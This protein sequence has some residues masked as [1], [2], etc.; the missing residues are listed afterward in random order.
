MLNEPEDYRYVYPDGSLSP[1]FG[2][3][4][5]SDAVEYT[6][7]HYCRRCSDRTTRRRIECLVAGQWVRLDL[8]IRICAGR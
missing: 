6:R 7:M 5:I 8:Y 1:T 3:V 2:A 4:S